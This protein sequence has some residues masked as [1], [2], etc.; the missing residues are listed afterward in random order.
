MLHEY[1]KSRILVEVISGFMAVD[2]ISPC[3]RPDEQG[4]QIEAA[5]PVDSVAAPGSQRG[6]DPNAWSETPRGSRM[7]WKARR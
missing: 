3:V 7:V 2:H 4:N 5:I 6:S 1:P